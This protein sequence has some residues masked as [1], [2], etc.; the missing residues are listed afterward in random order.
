VVGIINNNVT[1][2]DLAFD[3]PSQT[4][5]VPDSNNQRV[6][7][8]LPDR[9]TANLRDNQGNSYQTNQN[10]QGVAI[11]PT[12]D[13]FFSRWNTGA[14]TWLS[15]NLPQNPP[16]LVTNLN[17]PGRLVFD[18]RPATPVLCAAKTGAANSANCFAFS[19]A[20]NGSLTKQFTADLV[21]NPA[22]GGTNTELV[23]VAVGAVDT[24]GNYTL[25]L[26]YGGCALYTTSTKFDG[27]QP[28]TPTAVTLTGT[29]FSNGDTCADLGAL[30]S[31]D[32]VVLNTAQRTL[33]RVSTAG[34]GA[35]IVTG[36]AQPT[37]LD[38]GSDGNVYVLDRGLVG[39]GT[40]LKVTP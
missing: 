38:V 8:V 3:A 14:I 27:T 26:L 35:A 18:A 24:G 15:P 13:L 23:A 30:P 31:G 4:A 2:S 22:P 28:A 21:P 25:W 12:G 29:G 36:M 6:I 11:A 16:S 19:A 33:V 5:Y 9:T 1:G 39:N 32:V 10:V 34:A 17:G 37:G 7:V 40:I 20:S